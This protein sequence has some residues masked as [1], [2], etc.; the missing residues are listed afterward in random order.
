MRRFK[1][2]K[3][4]HAC[5]CTWALYLLCTV[6][7]PLQV[8]AD[9]STQESNNQQTKETSKKTDLSEGSQ[10]SNES[11]A[12]LDEAD[13]GP[14]IEGGNQ[15]FSEQALWLDFK[16]FAALYLEQAKEFKTVSDLIFK[17][18][19]LKKT[20]DIEKKYESEIKV[21]TES[22]DEQ[23]KESIRSFQA[24]LEDNK[25]RPHP[26]YTPDTLYRL[27]MLLL[28]DVDAEYLKAKERYDQKILTASEDEDIPLPQRNHE[29]VVSIFTKLITEWPN[30]RD[31]DS[32]YYARAHAYLESGEQQ[33]ALSDF[34]L[35]VQRFPNS[36][37]RTEVYNLIGEIY[38]DF[39]KLPQAIVAYKEV[40]KDQSSQYYLGAFYKMAW[41]YYRNDQFE[42][43]VEAF[44][45]LILTSD[46]MV[47]QGKKGFELRS[48]AIQ[49]LAISLNEDDWDDDGVIDRDAGY[50]RVARYITSKESYQAELLES[51]VD[52]FFE[53]SKYEDAIKVAQLLF[54][55]HPFYRN[56]PMIH[57]KTVT[58]FERIAQPDRA[59]STRDTINNAYVING[60]WYAYNH[61]DQEAI[62]Q[63]TKLMKDSLL[64]AA[65]YHHERASMLRQ[66]AMESETESEQRVLMNQAIESYRTAALSYQRY[67]D[68]YKKDENTYELLYLVADAF[69]FSGDYPNALKQYVNVRDS[70]LG[71]EHKEEAAFSAILAHMNVLKVAVEQGKIQAKPSLIDQERESSQVDQNP[72]HSDKNTGPKVIT[73]EELPPLAQEALALRQK[74]IDEKLSNEEDP[75]RVPVILYKV[76]EIYLDYQDFPKARERFEELIQSY[77]KS[78]VAEAAASALIE[79]YRMEENWTKMA[80]WA[81]KIA[82]SGLSSQVVT[83]AKL[84]KVGALYK[85]AQALFNQEKY[86]EA[87]LEYLSLV[88]QNPDNEF[89]AAAL[90]NGAVAFEKAVMFDSAMKTYERIYRQFPDSEFS[91]NALF[92]VAYNAER[93]YNYDKAVETF[94]E[95]AQR[96][97][98]GKH[99][100]DA[101]FNAARLLEQTQQ[102][103]RAA[104]AYI[105]FVDQYPDHEDVAQIY[106]GAATCYERLDDQK[107]ALK[108]YLNFIQRYGSIDKNSKLVISSLA[109]TLD[110]Y[111]KYGNNR[112]VKATRQKLIDEFE[113]R[114]LQ[115]G[116]YEARFP[117]QARFEQIEARFENFTRL[118]IK[119]SM[120][121]QG[122]IIKSM[123]EEIA[124]L[125]EEY[126]ALL[127][128][129]SLD[130]NIAAFYRIGL[131]RQLFSKALYN[132]PLPQGLSP[133]EEDIY[134]TQIEE[135]AIPIEDDAV[136][137][138]ETAYQKAREFRISNDWTR[139]I[140]LSLNQY[141]PAEYPTFKDEKRLEVKQLFTTSQIL[142]PTQAQELLKESP[143]AGS[144]TPDT[145]EDDRQETQAPSKGQRTPKVPDKTLEEPNSALDQQN[146]KEVSPNSE[147]MIDELD[148]NG[149]GDTL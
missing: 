70:K 56:N 148:L 104:N 141:K 62:D 134:V 30:Y 109:K 45:K 128:Y 51:M 47:K 123:K 33:Q 29:Q 41:S 12:L 28:E 101:S 119:G 78:S 110:I 80:E 76:G 77:P 98:E 111:K 95:L 17:E 118:K 69:Y 147:V 25:D 14:I 10:D 68:R 53:T 102:Y 130:W 23:R 63:A 89:A 74:Y 91:E 85:G 40:L 54:K 66:R 19:Y 112:A 5:L 16:R 107:N 50:K 120:R 100:A 21:A 7:I 67:L 144:A 64:Q 36:D 60:P 61:K 125:T 132:I 39:V 143:Q 4:H 32:A 81:E 146:I 6:S 13:L 133:E 86:K 140:L 129:K 71:T 105:R 137:R 46:Q 27:A 48:E 43:A 106:L 24:F 87:A 115:P 35:I 20:D 31:I 126:S 93:F 72:T 65:T 1:Q 34:E 26:I 42:Q 22:E 145:L 139:K 9:P 18:H 92:R 122:Q 113:R 75:E 142:L 116:S 57:A 49:Y 83:Q 99:A 88:E 114:G 44:K 84:W 108:I 149:E 138:F 59:F 97:K 58:A 117:A 131:L 38:F 79:T 103:K 124:G 136:Q 121:K 82:Q 11:E 2:M 8:D 96:Y 3:S 73:P 55:N 127:K 37:Y 90:N 52:I 94:V 135:I 15:E